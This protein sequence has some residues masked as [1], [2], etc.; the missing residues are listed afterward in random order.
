MSVMNV[1]VKIIEL[2]V[3]T[4]SS[5]TGDRAALRVVLRR[6]QDEG[7]GDTAIGFLPSQSRGRPRV[8]PWFEA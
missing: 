6:T 7:E 3:R 2:D 4:A 1:N 8:A 5:G